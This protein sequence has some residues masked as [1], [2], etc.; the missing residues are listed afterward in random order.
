MRTPQKHGKEHYKSNGQAK[1]TLKSWQSMITRCTDPKHDGYHRYGGSGITVC[2]R[3]EIY[4]NF[5]EDMGERPEGTTLDRL[6]NKKGYE[7]GNCRWA[8]L[9]TQN[10]NRRDNVYL[11]YNGKRQTMKQWAK[12]L[13]LS[14]TMIQQRVEYGWAV[15]KILTTPST[16]PPIMVEWQGKSQTLREWAKEL[17]IAFATLYRRIKTAKWDVDR[18]FTTP[19]SKK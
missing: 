15:E 8:N 9:E 17:D 14:Y 12:E 7:P 5:Y 4:L 6:D 18:A 10:N 3:W 19:V 1:P 2:E 11:E 16:C 13:G